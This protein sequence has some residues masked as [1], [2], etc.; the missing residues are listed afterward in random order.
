[1]IQILAINRRRLGKWADIAAKAACINRLQGGGRRPKA[2]F[3]RFERGKTGKF[4]ALTLYF[5]VTLSAIGLVCAV[6]EFRA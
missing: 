4:S 1:L 6:F 3:D 5:A 2:R